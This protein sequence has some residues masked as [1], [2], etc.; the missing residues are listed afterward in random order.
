MIQIML[1][2]GAVS[3]ILYR[4]SAAVSL[5]PAYRPSVQGD[6]LSRPAATHCLRKIFRL[7][8]GSGLR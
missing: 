1:D 8:E 3:K 6:A 7:I 5:L 4:L 2:R